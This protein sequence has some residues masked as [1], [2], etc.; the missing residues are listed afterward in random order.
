MNNLIIMFFILPGFGGGAD[1]PHLPHN[2]EC[3]QVVYT[4]THDNDT[5]RIYSSMLFPTHYIYLL[6]KDLGMH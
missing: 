3:N 2:H 5:V 4:G 1:N 6:R